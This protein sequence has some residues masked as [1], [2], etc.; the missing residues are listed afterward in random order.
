MTGL[1]S[2]LLGGLG[3]V[4]FGWQLPS[5]MQNNSAKYPRARDLL[6]LNRFIGFIMPVQ[7]L[8]GFIVVP[9]HAHLKWA[10]TVQYHIIP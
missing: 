4:W 5:K 1:P 3:L 6:S 2:S 9:S 8:M 10:I 7:K